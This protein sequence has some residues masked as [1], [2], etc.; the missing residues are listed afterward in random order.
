MRLSKPQNGFVLI[1]LLLYLAIS[2]TI[3]MA[4]SLFLAVLLSARVKS[5]TVAEV[6]QQG[7]QIMQ[8]ITQTTRNAESVNSPG[9]GASST[10]V[11]LNVV[12]SSLDPTIF[13]LNAGVLRIKEGTG[14]NVSL[15]NSRVTVSALNIQNLTRTGTPGVIRITFT[16][17]AVNPANRSEFNYSKTFYGSATLRHP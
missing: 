10:S 1:E 13:D 15:S 7:L 8:I 16:I 2:V 4:A 9:T 6:E 14:A 3:L 17:T 12:A 11:S 5:Q